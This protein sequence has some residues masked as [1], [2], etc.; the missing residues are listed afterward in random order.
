MTCAAPR[1]KGWM[2]CCCP[3]G[4]AGGAG[5]EVVVV[6]GVVTRRWE[7]TGGELGYGCGEMGGEGTY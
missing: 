1:D 3:H 2:G 5:E 6:E 4:E 7:G